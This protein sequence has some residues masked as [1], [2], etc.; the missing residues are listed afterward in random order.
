MATSI[1]AG[2]YLVPNSDEQI[3][4]EIYIDH[5][6][7]QFLDEDDNFILQITYEELRGDMAIMAAEQEKS[8]LRI[9]A[10]AKHN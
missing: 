7:I 5:A 8:H 3:V 9:I 4:P 6:L 10:A 2:I 1:M